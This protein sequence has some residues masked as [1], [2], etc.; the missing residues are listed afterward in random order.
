MHERKKTATFIIPHF[1]EKENKVNISHLEE[2]IASLFKQSDPNWQAIIIDD[3]SKDQQA[4]SFLSYLK[5]R[6]HPKIDVIFMP[7]NV[8]PGICRNI[9]VMYAHK[10]NSPFVLFN[11][12][13]DISHPHRLEQVRHTFESDSSIGLIYSTFTII[14]TQGVSVDTRRVPVHVQ[15]ILKTHTA[16]TI[17]EGHDAWIKMATETGY[18]N[19]TSSTSVRTNFASRCFF[20]A[21]YAS[22]DYHTWLRLSALGAK[23]KFVANIPTLYRIPTGEKQHASRIRIGDHEFNKIKIRIDTDGF[24]KALEIALAKG[25]IKPDITYALKAKFFKRQA[26]SMKNFGESELSKLMLNKH[27]LY[28]S[29]HGHYCSD[30]AITV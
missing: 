9:G 19:L 8:G 28:L 12:S 11:D 21:E 30:R 1:S 23:F 14:N 17:V 2:T 10:S 16:D 7:K 18:T 15:E 20:P 6:Y 4:L 24:D 26:Y 13:D 25:S 3:G 29:L 27:D 5:K 22:E